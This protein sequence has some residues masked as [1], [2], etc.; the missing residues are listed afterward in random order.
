MHHAISTEVL[1]QTQHVIFTAQAIKLFRFYTFYGFL[2]FLIHQKKSIKVR[3]TIKKLN[4]TK[5]YKR[6]M[7][8]RKQ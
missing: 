5:T 8:R 4:K 1:G 2:N 3:S 6:N 7:L